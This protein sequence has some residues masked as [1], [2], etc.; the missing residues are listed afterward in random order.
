MNHISI[1]LSFKKLGCPPQVKKK[2]KKEEE[3]GKKGK[4]VSCYNLF[5][6]STG[7]S[8]EQ[9][10]SQVWE[11]N[12]LNQIISTDY[13]PTECLHTAPHL[14]LGEH[15]DLP[16]ACFRVSLPLANLLANIP[17]IPPPSKCIQNQIFSHHLHHPC[18]PSPGFSN[19]ATCPQLPPRSLQPVF[20]P[21]I[22]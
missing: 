1:K 20:S 21:E 11:S 6:G 12:E 5:L 7:S 9:V 8:P 2:K 15:G 18:P 14:V 10:L 4:P 17:T 16:S 19:P 13:V 3:E 22:L